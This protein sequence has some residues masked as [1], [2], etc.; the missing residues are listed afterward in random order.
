MPTD[1]SSQP[2]GR[3]TIL[4]IMLATMA[5]VGAFAFLVVIMG[6]FVFHAL[7][8]FALLAC[9]GF[10][11]W[12]LWGRSMS[13]EVSAEREQEEDQITEEYGYWPDDGPHGPRRY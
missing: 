1:H 13:Q 3:E 6:V 10:A 8:I 2:S 11:H 5:I 7:G 12:L 4:T 9:F